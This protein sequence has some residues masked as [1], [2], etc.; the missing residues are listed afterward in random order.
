MNVN[1][2]LLDAIGVVPRRLS[3]LV[4]VSQAL[5]ALGAKVTGAGGSDDMGGVGSVLVLPGESGVRIE[6]AMETAGALAMPVKTGGEG[7]K[8]EAN[9]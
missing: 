5:G 1:H 3:E 7:L 9:L 4:K 2:G 6:A 8:I